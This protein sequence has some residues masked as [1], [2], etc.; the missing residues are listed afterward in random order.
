MDLATHTVVASSL[1]VTDVNQIHLPLVLLLVFGTAKLLAYVCER[2]GQPG[3]V[4]EIIG[5]VVLGPSVLNWVRP[6]EVLTAL[7]EMG[8]IFLL[9]RVGLEVKA[10]DLMRVGSTALTTAVLGVVVP[11]VLGS[12]AMRVAGVST[13]EAVF[14]GAA[15]VATS[16]GITARV[17]ASKGLLQLRASQVIL[18]AAVIDDVLGLLVLACVESTAKGHFNSVALTTTVAVA[19][20]F[21]VL[22]AQYGTRTVQHMMPKLERVLG[23]EEAQFHLAMVLLFALA[24]SAVSL[25][26]GAIVGAFLAGMTLSETVK[27][28]VHDLAHGITELLVPF[29]LISIGLHLD[30]SV[31]TNR[32]T[33]WLTASICAAALLSKV[34]GCGLGAW[35]L[36]RADMLRVG[37]GMI[38]RGEV[39]MVVAQIGLS[40][41]VIEK[42]VYAAVVCM[43]IVTTLVAPP[44]LKYAYRNCRP[45]VPQ[46][47][48]RIA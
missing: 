25:G 29:F 30:V 22:V 28:R 10:S 20:A 37:V 38:P 27:Q 14:V 5:G 39:G 35:R 34:V 40:M 2:F 21:T 15:L 19:I 8:A 11:F 1:L 46:Q 48:F 33:L 44:M 3:L 4:G 42:P 47:E 17:L 6:D 31:F 32:V 26:I 7:A 18:A 45:G 13:I 24:L 23:M 41:G 43:A 16:I 12:I 36:G 9:F